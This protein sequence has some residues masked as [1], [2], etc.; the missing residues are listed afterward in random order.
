M[1]SPNFADFDHELLSMYPTIVYIKNFMSLD[2]ILSL[3]TLAHERYTRSSVVGPNSHYID[4][5]RTSSSCMFAPHETETVKK[6]EERASRLAGTDVSCIEGL[7]IVKY[8]VG[9]HYN[10]HF[11]WFDRTTE[12]GKQEMEKGGQRRLTILVYLI[13][14]KSGGSTRFPQ[15]DLNVQPKMGDAILFYNTTPTHNDD[16]LTE[17]GGMPV[18]EGTKIAMNIWVRESSRN[19]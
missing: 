15:I 5:G 8:E 4:S 11:D 18:K 17:H 16:P 9:E 6:I 13:E 14:P 7:Q 2:E 19:I 10:T 12:A 3:L 1:S